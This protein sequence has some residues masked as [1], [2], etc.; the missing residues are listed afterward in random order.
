MHEF[1]SDSPNHIPF[2]GDSPDNDNT[3]NDT[4]EYYSPDLIPTDISP[5]LHDAPDSASTEGIIPV[6]EEETHTIIDNGEIVIPTATHLF[7]GYHKS[8]ATIT[9]IVAPQVMG[10]RPEG[11]TYRILDAG[12]SSGGDTMSM[13]AVLALNGVTYHID[14]VDVNSMAIAQATLPYE[15]TK[16]ELHDRLRNWDIPERTLDFFEEVDQHRIQPAAA[17]RDNITF[18]QADLRQPLPLPGEYDVAVANNMLLFYEGRQ[19]DTAATMVGNIVATLRVGGIFT[20][21]DRALASFLLTDE[22]L[23]THGL[24]PAENEY[25]I[26]DETWSQLVIYRK[27]G[28]S[29]AG[30]PQQSTPHA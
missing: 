16:T 28:E 17:L 13:A 5:D 8:V 26:S 25:G 30:N 4:G 24:E 7:R 11:S 3:G 6:V 29:S 22:L 21:S 12:C 1:G 9:N 19:P 10:E 23:Q 27:I 18:H 20:F 2:D 15:I 14:A